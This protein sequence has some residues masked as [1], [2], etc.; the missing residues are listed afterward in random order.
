MAGI[1]LSLGHFII[2]GA[3]EH[4]KYNIFYETSERRTP[5]YVEPIRNLP[6]YLHVAQIPQNYDHWR[7]GTYL[8]RRT[9]GRLSLGFFQQIYKSKRNIKC[10]LISVS[11]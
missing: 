2:V 5:A 4:K 8:R 9:T 3:I 1:S 10:D 7:L 6:E 11:E